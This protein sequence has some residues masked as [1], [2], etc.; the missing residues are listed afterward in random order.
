[1]EFLK[2]ALISQVFGERDMGLND[3]KQAFILKVAH[4]YTH[5][6]IL[7]PWCPMRQVLF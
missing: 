1:M 7:F 4:F 6:L 3:E 2:N 5:Y